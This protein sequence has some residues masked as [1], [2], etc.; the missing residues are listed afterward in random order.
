[1][2]N[3]LSLHGENALATQKF[4]W[5]SNTRK[6]ASNEYYHHERWN[7]DLLQGLGHW[8]GHYVLAW[9]AVERRHVGW[10]NALPGAERLSRS[11]ARPSWA[12]AIQ[13]GFFRQ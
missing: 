11:R 10:T 7:A 9:L 13:P 2:T 4:T 6:E 1:M 12:R 8:P 5:C 3:V